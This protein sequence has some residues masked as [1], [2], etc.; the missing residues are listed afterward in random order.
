MGILGIGN[1]GVPE[2]DDDDDVIAGAGSTLSISD[3]EVRGAEWT[4]SPRE[5]LIVNVKAV[6]LSFEASQDV[7]STFS[8]GRSGVTVIIVCEGV[9]GL[10]EVEGHFGLRKPSST[11]TLG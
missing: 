5:C 8:E 3:G 4:Q 2:G 7:K 11:G 9:E 6:G 10:L 1:G